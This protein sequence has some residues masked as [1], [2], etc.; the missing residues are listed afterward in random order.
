[1][2]LKISQLPIASLPLAGTEV[3]PIVQSSQTKQIQV[4]NLLSDP[5]L[6]AIAA[7]ATT[8]I[9]VRTAS[10]TWALESIQGTANQIDIVNGDG[11]AGNPVVSLNATVLAQ[12]AGTIAVANAAYIYASGFNHANAGGLV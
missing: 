6:I 3:V 12:L 4:A 2:D 10:N 7:L 8:G 9:L 5:D 11:V 1:V